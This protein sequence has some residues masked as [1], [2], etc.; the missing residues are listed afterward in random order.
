[1]KKVTKDLKLNMAANSKWPQKK[2]FIEDGF[3]IKMAPKFGFFCYSSLSET[4]H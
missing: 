1:L 2:D 4:K 3:K